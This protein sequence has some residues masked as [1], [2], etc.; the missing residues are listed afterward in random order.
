VFGI[1]AAWGELELHESGFRAEYARPH[2]LLLPTDRSDSYAQRVRALAAGHDAEVWE[3]DSGHRLHRRYVEQ[4]LGL[5]KAAIQGLLAPQ[6]RR[7]RLRRWRETLVAIAEAAMVLVVGGLFW[8][9]ILVAVIVSL[10]SEGVDDPVAG[11]LTPGCAL[12]PTASSHPRRH[13]P[14]QA[15]RGG[16]PAPRPA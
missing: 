10:F 3:V 13:S 6:L 16:A 1:G 5:S 14:S 4:N 2:A 8:G 9:L 11:P 15:P 12:P 7:D